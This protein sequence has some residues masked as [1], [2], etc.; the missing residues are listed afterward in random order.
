[1]EIL[2]VAVVA[3]CNIACFAIGAKVGQRVSRGEEITLPK[4]EPMAAVRHR[5]ETKE[6]QIERERTE[7]I[8]R[9]IDLYD[10]SGA[11]QEDVPGR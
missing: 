9:N 1:M 7:A 4:P 10:G 6:A 8:L 3:I 11:H 5:Q 2:L